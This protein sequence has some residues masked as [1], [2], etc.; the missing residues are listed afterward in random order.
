MPSQLAIGWF[1]WRPSLSD[2]AAA[3]LFLFYFIFIVCPPCNHQQNIIN[4][5]SKTREIKEDECF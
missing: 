1:G 2:S 4:E 5:E 3:A